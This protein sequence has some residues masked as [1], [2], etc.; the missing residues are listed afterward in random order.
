MYSDWTMRMSQPGPNFHEQRRVFRQ[1]LGPH[2]IGEYDTLIQ[3][4]FDSFCGA[5]SSVSGNPFPVIVDAVGAIVTK[6]GYGDNVYQAHGEE[7]VR[8]NRQRIE[9]I[10]WAFTKFWMVDVFPLL[11]F[12]P[13]WFP[14]AN[15]RKIGETGT[16]Q[17]KQIRFWPYEM[18]HNAVKAGNADDSVLA[19]FMNHPSFSN[20]RLRDAVALMYTT[21]VDTT[22]S[23]ILNLFYTML[24]HP[25]HQKKLQAELDTV[26]AHGRAISMQDIHNMPYFNAVW[27][28]S[29]RWSTPAPLGL[30]HV[31]SE[32]DVW[33]GYFIP[34]GSAI[35]FN[36]GFMMRDPRIWGEDAEL[37]RP[38]RFLPEY[39]PKAG[40]LPDM[41]SLPF[42]FG[43]RICPGRYLAERVAMQLTVAT[44]SRFEVVP[45]DGEVVSA[46][47]IE[48]EDST[49]RRPSNL[50]CQ[51]KPRQA[52][53]SN[54]N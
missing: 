29:L 31:N 25:E 27:K 54:V 19:R 34:K 35:Y 5:L 37:F 20:E 15:F 3:R 36:I 47:N 46:S 13:S 52:Y 4:H 49:V 33:N 8:V 9:L 44:L 45:I 51:F 10:T 23:A 48:Y 2:V 1:A 50:R 32:D 53:K 17:A 11:R 43:L 6:L 39:N 42:G 26:N 7:L 30:P 38:E 24:L 22:S 18:V 16:R 41:S 14:G 40:N 12:I 28:E 21:G